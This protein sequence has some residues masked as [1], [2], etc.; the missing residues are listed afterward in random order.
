M[1]RSNLFRRVRESFQSRVFFL[2]TFLILVTS[3]AFTALYLRNERI[4]LS[5]RLVAEG[6]LLARLLAYN[7]RLAVFA[8]QESM[9]RE[10]ADG[11]LQHDNVLSAAVVGADGKI[12]TIR[13]KT[14]NKIASGAADGPIP[15]A[16]LPEEANKTIH[17][18]NAD[19]MEFF[20]PVIGGSGY[21][22]PESLYFNGTPS[23]REGRNIGLVRVILD[24]KN[25]NARLHKLLV[26]SLLLAMIFLLFGLAAAYLVV[27]SV[28]KPLN[29]LLEG[30]KTLGKG[31]LSGRIP[32]A[33]EDELGKVS[34]SFNFMAEALERREAE[35]RELGEQL[36]LAQQQEAKE[37]WERTFDAVPDLIAILDRE[38]RVVRINK[39]MAE[40]LQIGKD[41]AVGRKLYELF[42]GAELTA[43][44]PRLYDL[45]DADGIFFTEFCQERLQRFFLVT[46]SPLLKNDGSMIGSVFVARDITERKR[47]EEALRNS[48]EEFRAL[49]ETSRDAIM[50]L[51]RQGFLDCN[52]ATLDMFGCESKAQ[53]F[54]KQLEELSPPQ[55]QDG[56]DSS[57]AIRERLEAAYVEGYQ[58]FEWLHRR[59]DGTLF[60]AEA[61]F[62]R[63]ELHGKTVLQ[64]VLRDITERKKL[65][66][67]LWQS[68]KMEAIGQLAGGVAHDFNNILTAIIGFANLVEMGM[69]KQDPS[70]QYLEQVLAAAERATH[71][72]QGLLAF[73]RRQVINP[74]P[75]DL[76]SVII[77]VEKLL[78]RLISEEIEL[79]ISLA[80]RD[81]VVMADSGQ[82]DQI[83]MNLATNARDAMP[84]GG[85]LTIE[86]SLFEMTDDYIK[87]Y[88][89]GTPGLY[90]MLAI[91]DTGDGMA[92]ATRA[93]IFEPFFTTK[94]VGKGTGLG[95]AVVYGIVKQHNGFINVYSEP[96]KGTTF[97]I[98]LP[99]VQEEKAQIHS[100]EE[101]QAVVGGVETLLVV[102]D[103]PEVLKLS[104]ALLETY[105]YRVIEAVDGQDAVEKFVEHQDEIKLVIMD[106]VMP[107]MNGKEA[108]AEMARMR[109]GVKAL[110][111]SGYTPNVVHKKGILLEG[112]HFIP[113]PSQ[114][115]AL[116]KKI[117]KVLG[118]CPTGS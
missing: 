5:E 11:I 77:N 7:S 51:D 44:F 36:R 87:T 112:V 68:Q 47:S 23:A 29:S 66:E 106:V 39:A 19:N 116:L 12:L 30:V 56:K 34:L 102:E 76:N 109:P 16:G 91:R 10:V 58:F 6:E 48:E 62:N 59:M 82:I 61:L 60:P 104:K 49:F 53:F 32:V 52:K 79:T 94:E 50:I 89:F 8:E 105:G 110:F 73:S 74:Q 43:I 107:K 35:N 40:L 54:V 113:K 118:P 83:L 31:D 45:H 13:V 72:T 99:L 64:A 65:K 55:Q 1:V 98:N 100:P 42:H 41:G 3:V 17:I 26:T 90:A 2:L 14:G 69:D 108:L 117:R 63:F 15:L 22:S 57:S 38:D 24:K 4:S 115:Q 86:T 37:E 80:D 25:L 111:T 27:K 84:D 70:M 46:V 95:L 93:R 96:G 92:E 88:G 81:L 101:L 75:I 85:A 114:P 33:T 103:N 67:Q 9:L 18:D 78:N 97:K 71:L 28:T 21:S 20:A